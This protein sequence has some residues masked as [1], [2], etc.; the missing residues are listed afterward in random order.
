MA[1]IVDIQ[2]QLPQYR[3]SQSDLTQAL[4]AYLDNSEVS[5]K[6]VSRLH[7]SVQVKNR[8][9]SMPIEAYL[10]LHNF[11]E[12]NHAY[13]EIALSL[14]ELCIR[15]LLD[16]CQLDA[17]GIS[18]LM[19]TTVTG[20]SVPSIDARLMNRIPFSSHLKRVPIFG[21]GCVAGAAGISRSADYL[22]GHPHDSVILLAIELC[23]LTIQQDDI[24]MANFVGS[25]LFGDGAAAILM[26]GDK[27]PLAKSAKTQ[28]VATQSDFYPNTEH[29]MGWQIGTNGFKLI[30]SAEVPHVAEHILPTSVFNFLSKNELKIHDIDHWIS[31]PGGPKVITAIEKGLGLNS[32]S[33]ALSRESLA[34][35]GNLSSASV[36]A[37]FEKTL[38]ERKPQK[39]EQGLLLAM[40]PGFCSEMVLLSW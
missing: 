3:Y 10:S 19:F 5:P 21:L 6:L 8:H 37:I 17:Q 26:V 7:E 40:G 2:T 35:I 1:Y 24:S 30:L 31:H 27:H 33:L 13:G 15:N 20:L 32:D 18:Q 36:L 9:L 25:G 39:N 14:G 29:V 28:I 34:D 38:I 4:L 12:R 16:K 11:T 22:K 23:S